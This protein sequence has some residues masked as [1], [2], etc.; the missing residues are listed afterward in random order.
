MVRDDLSQGHDA[1]TANKR[2]VISLLQLHIFLLVCSVKSD[3]K[4]AENAHITI[5]T[6]DVILYIIIA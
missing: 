4:P 3:N 2:N 5:L 6:S 1:L